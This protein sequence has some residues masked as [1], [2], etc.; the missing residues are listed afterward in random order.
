MDPIRRDLGQPVLCVAE[1]WFLSV[2]QTRLLFHMRTRP[3]RRFWEVSNWEALPRQGPSNRLAGTSTHH[4]HQHMASQTHQRSHRDLQARHYFGFEA[5]HRFLH[6][7]YL[8]TLITDRMI[9]YIQSPQPTPDWGMS[10]IL[11]QPPSLPLCLLTTDSVQWAHTAL[12]D[13]SPTSFPPARFNA[14][15]LQHPVFARSSSSLLKQQ[16]LRHSPDDDQS[17]LIETSSCNLRFF[18]EL[19]ATQL[20]ISHGVTANSLYLMT[21]KSFLK[22]HGT[23]PLVL[24]AGSASLTNPVEGVLSLIWKHSNI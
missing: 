4:T 13:P 12:P 19:I 2:E 14:L 18:S 16:R 5:G 10:Y 23:L 20:R 15:I 11:S 22:S 21:L 1:T 7:R 24:P 3:Q 8:A 6:Q 17:M 9:F